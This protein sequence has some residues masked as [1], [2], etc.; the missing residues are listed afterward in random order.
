M[1]HGQWD[2]LNLAKC[3]VVSFTRRRSRI[4]SIYQVGSTWTGRVNQV[5]DLG[6]FLT[7]KM[8]MNAHVNLVVS[9]ALSV[10]GIVKRFSRGFNNQL[11]TKALCCALIRPRLEYACAVWSPYQSTYLT[12]LE[13]VQKKFV[14]FALP[15]RRDSTTYRLPPYNDRL[16][17]LG[18]EPLW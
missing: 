6:V 3:H 15:Y 1:V 18:L 17:E 5:I 10:L 4:S 14:M 12:K 9:R 13:S 11:V 8:D 2:G 16:N 7:E